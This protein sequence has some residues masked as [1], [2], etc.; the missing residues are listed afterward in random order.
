M[1]LRGGKAQGDTIIEVIF[2]IVIFSFIA[3]SSLA[4][5]NQGIAT[6]EKALEITLV[7]QQVNAQAEALRY[8]HAASVASPGSDEAT[9]WS[10]VSH[11]PSEEYPDAIGQ[12]RASDY[13]V[14]GG[15]CVVPTEG[16]YQPF[17]VNAKTA[18]IWSGVPSVSPDANDTY[19]P[20][21]QVVYNSD[22][23]IAAAYGM[24]VE[25]VPSDGDVDEKQ[26]V[27]FHIRACWPAPGSAVPMTIG[28]I[29]R[30]YDPI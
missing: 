18:Q 7:R 29:V 16:Q 8:I 27:D 20:Y 24:W 14:D 22:A 28:T 2:A 3:I 15:Q 11:V 19:P 26:F 23:S 5:M 13:G 17:I 6:G 25:S 10:N 30:L 4:I 21:S 12:E 9:T 1:R